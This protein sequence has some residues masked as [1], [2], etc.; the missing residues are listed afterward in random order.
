L[1]D[2]GQWA[3]LQQPQGQWV[4]QH[5]AGPNCW[6]LLLLWQLHHQYSL[7]GYATDLCVSTDI[8]WS[9]LP[10]FPT[11]RCTNLFWW[12]TIFWSVDQQRR[13]D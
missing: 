13:A 10:H 7:P 6:A 4:V 5:H 3:S 2:L 12:Q 11:G 9:W 8:N 1:Q